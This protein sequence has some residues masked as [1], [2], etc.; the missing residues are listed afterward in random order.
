MKNSP[1]FKMTILLSLIITL[2]ACK[3]AQEPKQSTPENVPLAS[4]VLDTLVH[5]YPLDYMKSLDTLDASGKLK[6]G[7]YKDILEL[8]ENL[9]Y[10]PEAWQD[11]IREIPRVYITEIGDRWGTTTTKEITVENKKRIFFFVEL[12]H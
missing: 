9:N 10:T 1:L 2:I 7:S 4:L 12:R 8:F 5:S 6:V 11:G 3:D